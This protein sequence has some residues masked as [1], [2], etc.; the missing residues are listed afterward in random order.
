MAS[1]GTAEMERVDRTADGLSVREREVCQ[2]LLLSSWVRVLPLTGTRKTYLEE[3]WL[4]W[5]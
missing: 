4:G 1:I 3:N 5:K 2:V